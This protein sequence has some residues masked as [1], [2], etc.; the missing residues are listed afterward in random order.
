MH[1]YTIICKHILNIQIWYMT[2]IWKTIE[3][4]T[5]VDDELMLVLTSWLGIISCRTSASLALRWGFL[6]RDLLPIRTRMRSMRWPLTSI[7]SYKIYNGINY[8]IMLVWW[9]NKTNN[10]CKPKVNMFT[11]LELNN[12]HCAMPFFRLFHQIHT[13][14]G[15]IEPKG[16]NQ[17]LCQN[18]CCYNTIPFTHST[19]S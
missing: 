2:N 5:Y 16:L 18:T 7:K 10:I 6:R 19:T 8:I 15:N 3:I 13:Y 1:R 9:G 17:L 4:N 11:I 12:C 14:R